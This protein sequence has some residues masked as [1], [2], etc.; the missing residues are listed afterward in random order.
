MPNGDDV[1]IGWFDDELMHQAFRDPKVF[2][3]EDTYFMVIAGGKLRIYSSTD[4]LNW[5][6]ESSYGDRPN[7]SSG[8]TVETECPDLYRLPIEGEDGWKWV[9]GYGGRRYQV[10]EFVQLDG[11]WQFVADDDYAE[12][13]AMN[14][15]NDSYAAMTYYISPS[16]DEDT[17]ER[18]IAYNWMN[19]W[20]YC[21]VVDD[22]NGND[23]F[24]GTFNLNLELSLA[25]DKTGRLILKQI[26]IA[27]YGQMVFPAENVAVSEIM[28]VS[29]G[30]TVPV[31]GFEGD[32][33]LMELVITPGSGTTKAGALVR[34]GG[35]HSVSVDYG[36]T[37]DALTINRGLSG[38]N[39]SSASFSHVVTEERTDGKVVLHIY[40]DRC[41]LEA[42]SGNYTAAGA[43]LIFPDEQDTGAALYAEGGSCDFEVTITQASSI[44]S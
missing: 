41:S 30:S 6:L 39:F 42:F 29:A 25:R 12:P 34:V 5:K 21:T 23:R 1:L 18:V 2:K 14:F 43:M 26:P 40:V 13:V 8:L 17:Q 20:D 38:G 22:F 7:N 36:L 32:S 10:G 16:F 19:S 37:T 27:E 31:E 9:L 28:T 15:G 4:L 11:K 3:Y 44:W 35:E 24:N 33:Y